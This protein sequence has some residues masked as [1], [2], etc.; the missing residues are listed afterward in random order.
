MML[1]QYFSHKITSIFCPFQSN[2]RW[3]APRKHNLGHPFKGGWS[4]DH[5]SNSYKTFLSQKEN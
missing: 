2:F 1:N 5:N 3:K 4:I